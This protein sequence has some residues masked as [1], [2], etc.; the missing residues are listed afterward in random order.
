LNHK[1][2]KEFSKIVKIHHPS[3]IVFALSFLDDYD[4]IEL[5]TKIEIE[6]VAELF[7]YFPEQR[8]DSL[9]QLMPFKSVVELFELIPSDERADLFNRI[10]EETQKKLLPALAKAER[11]DIIKLASYPEGTVGS[12][13]SSDYLRVELNM[14]VAETISFIRENAMDKDTIYVI[15]VTD[16]ENKLRG[17]I[18]LKDLILAREKDII[19]E[20]MSSDI[21]YVN[22]KSPREEAAKLIQEYDLL[23]LPVVDDDMKMIGIVTV[24]DAMDIEQETNTTQLTKFGGIVP[25]GK[26]DDLDITTTPF[27]KMFK[28]RSF[29]LIL[30]TFFGVF[31]STYV[32][33]QE[34]LLSKV[35]VLAAFI[36]PIV[37]MG[38]NTGSQSATLVIRAMA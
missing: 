4:I 33:A 9:I 10:S 28:D 37:D 17:I 30:L 24:D 35:V 22:A 2:T 1:I 5:L 3:D 6:L 27:L 20:I 25:L 38:G 13:T 29:W 32:A 8:Q 19:R 26:T 18:S 7:L 15:Y 12:E 14:T 31:T 11:E 21:I 23:A 36:A 34:E 16:P